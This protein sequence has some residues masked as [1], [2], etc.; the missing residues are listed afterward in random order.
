MA[1]IELAS[2]KVFCM[3]LRDIVSFSPPVGGCK[4]LQCEANETFRYRVL[5]DS[6]VRRDAPYT[7]SLNKYNDYVSVSDL[8]HIIVAYDNA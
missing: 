3:V 4:Y 1:R 2:K 6:G 8:G 7:D 5:Q